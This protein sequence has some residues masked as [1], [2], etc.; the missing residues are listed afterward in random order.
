M[1][2]WEFED[3]K[4]DTIN[5]RKLKGKVV[6]ID[7]W[8]TWCGPC[9]AEVPNLVSVYQKYHE[10]GFEILGI[11]LDRSRSQLVSFLEDHKMNWP[12]YYDGKG[13]KI[14]TAEN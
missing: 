9:T 3:L 4:G 13:W 7:F 10:K 8:A 12:Q 11:S 2:P 14:R 1:K 5:T 6:L